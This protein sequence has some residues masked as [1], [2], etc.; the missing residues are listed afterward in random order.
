M[1]GKKAVTQQ[2]T[3]RNNIFPDFIEKELV[4]FMLIKEHVPVVTTIIDVVHL[5]RVKSHVKKFSMVIKK[6][7][8]N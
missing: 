3:I 6:K 1:I 4:M 5:V 7:Y 2:V 8:T